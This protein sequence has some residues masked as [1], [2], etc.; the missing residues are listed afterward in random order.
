MDVES[1][2]AACDSREKEIKLN[3]DVIQGQ[4]AQLKG[5]IQE[6][7]GELTE[8]EIDR[9]A[10]RKEQLVGKLQE[11]YG[12][13]KADADRASEEWANTLDRAA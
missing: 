8:D 10:G 12:Y 6:T 13:A 11:K 4:W 9:I 3:W 2:D 1:P 5:K 7:W